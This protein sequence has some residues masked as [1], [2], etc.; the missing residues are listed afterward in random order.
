MMVYLLNGMKMGGKV[1]KGLSSMG[2]KM[3]YK[4]IGIEMER[5]NQKGLSRMGN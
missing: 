4:L 3:D 5:K 1:L 2:K